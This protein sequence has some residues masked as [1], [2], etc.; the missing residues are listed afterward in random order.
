MS[1]LRILSNKKN[2]PPPFKNM[3][4]FKSTYRYQI[5]FKGKVRGPY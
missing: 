2:E 5:I 3:Y 1:A 4:N